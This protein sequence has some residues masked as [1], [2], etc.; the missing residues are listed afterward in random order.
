MTRN[1]KVLFATNAG[2]L[3]NEG[4]PVLP[5]HFPMDGGCSC[6]RSRCSSIGK[7]PI[8]SQGLRDASLDERVIQVW[9][10]ACPA[11]NIGIAAGGQSGFF[12]LDIDEKS[13][14]FDSLRDL[15]RTWG[16]LPDTVRVLTGGGGV[17]YYFAYPKSGFVKTRV[18]LCPGIDVR[19]DGSYVVAP[20]SVHA[21][22]RTYEWEIDHSPDDIYLRPAPDWLVSLINDHQHSTSMARDLE[23]MNV[24]G[25]GS[26][27]MTLTRLVGLLLGN[28]IPKGL[29]LRLTKAFNEKYARPP[30]PNSEIEQIVMSIGRRE[31][32]KNQR[33]F[34][35]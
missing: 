14:G 9:S 32:S 31:A 16:E 18:S 12:V 28:G 35:D 6:R 24:L 19:S 5:L 21:S 26:R 7:H 20:P 23:L 27:N 10:A 30:L 25:E 33:R 15:E 22:G 11:A 1:S 3:I 29:V 13:G 4:W 17:H 2:A 34:H 8:T